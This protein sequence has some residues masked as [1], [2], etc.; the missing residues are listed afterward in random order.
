MQ[1]YTL[2]HSQSDIHTPTR[3]YI[4]FPH[5]FNTDNHTHICSVIRLHGFPLN[6][7]QLDHQLGDTERMCGWGT[8]LGSKLAQQR[9]V[10]HRCLLSRDGVY[11]QLSFG[12]IC[13]TNW[14]PIEF[15]CVNLLWMKPQ[16]SKLFLHYFHFKEIM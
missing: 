11:A 16:L 1:T 10:L 13:H 12:T 3:I 7:R 14:H 8:Q 15:S 6:S 5:T 2:I 4:H 9:S